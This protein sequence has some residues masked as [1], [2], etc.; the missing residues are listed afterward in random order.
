MQKA[1]RQRVAK[2][3][4]YYL[5]RPW[6]KNIITKNI[7]TIITPRSYVLKPILVEFYLYS[8][9]RSTPW[10]FNI[11]F[12]SPS[13]LPSFLPIFI[14]SSSPSSTEPKTTPSLF[15][16]IFLT[17]FKAN[18]IY[19][20]NFATLLRLVVSMW[21]QV[22]FHSPYRG[23][24][25]LSLAVLVHYR[26]LRVFSLGPRPARIP[27]EFL[28]NRGTWEKTTEDPEGFAYRALTF[29]GRFFQIFL[30]PL[31]F[32]TSVFRIRRKIG[33]SHNPQRNLSPK[34]V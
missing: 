4:K 24:F 34:T 16:V 19:F 9:F 28:V 21:F 30:L 10:T 29:Y 15:L 13:F 31:D 33:F 25:H 12:Y 6:H 20:L 26:S 3:R 5:Q 18:I 23:S 17:L 7:P 27:T 2:L 8:I 14:S 32:V 1:H 22:L 11:S